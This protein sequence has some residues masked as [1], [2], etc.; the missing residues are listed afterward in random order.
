MKKERQLNI[1]ALRI[2]A[3]ICTIIIHITNVYFR[4]YPL[5]S[6]S[7]YF[8]AVLFNSLARICVPVFFMISGS[9]LIPREDDS[10]KYWKRII[11]FFIVLVVWSLIYMLFY[12]RFSFKGIVM[13]LFNAEASSRHLWYMYALLGI[14]L[15]LPFIRKMCKYLT[16]KEE[17]LFLI[18]WCIFSGLQIIYIPVARGI[19]N[20]NIDISY[21]IPFVEVAYYLGYFICGHILYKRYDNYKRNK[22]TNLYLIL[23]YLS[24]SLITAICTYFF[25]MLFDKRCDVFFWYKS[26]FIIISS[27]CIFLLFVINKDKFKSEKLLLFSK[28]TFG[29]YLIHGIFFVSLRKIFTYTDYNSLYMTIPVAIVVYFVSWIATYILKKIPLIKELL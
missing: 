10:K 15:T 3:I 2:V 23:G 14:Y 1:E 6:D 29:I 27:A 16:E 21:P 12:N 7:Y 8:F 18:L 4:K 28:Y 25:T 20:Y 24:S 19:L 9:L 26:I 22:R 17:N 5:I 13:S 11:K